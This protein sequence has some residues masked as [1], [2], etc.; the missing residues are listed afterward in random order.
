[1]LPY[2][3]CGLTPAS[4]TTTM[5]TIMSILLAATLLLPFVSALP[6]CETPTTTV[7][8]LPPIHRQRP[9]PP[10]IH[11][12]DAIFREQ[13]ATPPAAV[14]AAEAAPTVFA[15]PP[16][17]PPLPPIPSVTRPPGQDAALASQGYTQV[18]YYSCRTAGAGGAEQCGWHMPLRKVVYEGAAARGT[19]DLRVVMAA[20]GGAVALLVVG[21][22]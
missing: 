4:T 2:T 11:P 6:A 18:T 21:V 20:A 12:T 8:F 13:P 3:T 16:A 14:V 10:V 5:R 9:P 22:L 7:P 1:M 15:P 17:P 19:A